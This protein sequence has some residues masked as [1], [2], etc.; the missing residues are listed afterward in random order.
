MESIERKMQ[1]IRDEDSETLEVEDGFA[2]YNDDDRFPFA[3]GRA[4][5]H[6]R[7]AKNRSNLW[8]SQRRLSSFRV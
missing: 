2:R 3:L 7:G 5:N 1:G 4:V 8:S 6:G